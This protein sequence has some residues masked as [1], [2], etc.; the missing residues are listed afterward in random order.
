MDTE[1]TDHEITSD[2]RT[3]LVRLEERMDQVRGLGKVAWGIMVLMVINLGGGLIGYGSLLQQ[4]ESLNLIDVKRD[5]STALLMLGD[6]GTEFADIRA[7]QLRQ[8]VQINAYEDK[9]DDKTR[10]RFYKSDGA[11]LEQQHIK[12]ITKCESRLD[13]LENRVFFKD[14]KLSQNIQ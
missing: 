3:R 2:I 6:Q 8:R 5:V 4:V 7:E 13:R 10:A 12:D 1:M 14:D 11:R 9:L